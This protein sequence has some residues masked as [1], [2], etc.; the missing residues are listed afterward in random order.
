MNIK[1]IIISII[2]S[3]LIISMCSCA[4]QPAT[5][6]LEPPGEYKEYIEVEHYAL[7]HKSFQ[8][9][10]KDLENGAGISCIDMFPQ[11]LI[12]DY[13]MV[14]DYAELDT[15][16]WPETAYDPGDNFDD[17]PD[18]IVRDHFAANF[19]FADSCNGKYT[20]ESGHSKVE[21]II[22]NYRYKDG[23]GIPQGFEELNWDYPTKIYGKNN[24]YYRFKINDHNYCQLFVDSTVDESVVHY[25]ISHTF[26]VYGV[27]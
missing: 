3:M 24:G 25:L 26:E 20:E 1:K 16:E 6:E 8:E 4:Q 10:F 27:E 19:C 21:Y 9:T 7:S 13:S 2:L 22:Y 11:K 23:F 12:D 5:T 17:K 15:F 18:G 14:M